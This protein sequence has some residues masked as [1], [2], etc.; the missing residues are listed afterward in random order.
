MDDP[1]TPIVGMIYT[2]RRPSLRR[3]VTALTTDSA[4]SY[5]HYRAETQ[6][7]WGVE[8]SC[9]ISTWDAWAS[10]EPPEKANG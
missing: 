8:R 2:G 1:R 5:V 6:A 10:N 9:Y 4:G 7:R 3:L